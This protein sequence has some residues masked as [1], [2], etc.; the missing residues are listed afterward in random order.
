MYWVST[1]AVPRSPGNSSIMGRIIGTP[2]PC[3]SPATLARYGMS[4]ILSRVK[5]RATSTASSSNAQGTR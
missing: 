5:V 4:D 2:C 1:P 3:A